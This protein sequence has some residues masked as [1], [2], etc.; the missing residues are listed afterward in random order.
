MKKS[1]TQKSGNNTTTTGPVLSTY[2]N[3]TDSFLSVPPTPIDMRLLPPPGASERRG[4]LRFPAPG[5][6]IIDAFK[7]PLFS[8]PKLPPRECFLF[9]AYA[10]DFALLVSFNS[11]TIP[12]SIDHSPL[13]TTIASTAFFFSPTNS[14]SRRPLYFE[15]R[16]HTC[17]A[18]QQP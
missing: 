15:S 13:S 11:Y 14:S 6:G 4:P 17:M 3:P 9:I 10:A 7:G 18:I 5:P 12:R 8:L 16:F 2:L 1:S